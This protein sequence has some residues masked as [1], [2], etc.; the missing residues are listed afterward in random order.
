ML[1]DKS[2]LTEEGA[3]ADAPPQDNP[4]DYDFNV[5]FA[6]DSEDE[7]G[8]GGFDAATGAVGGLDDS[9]LQLSR[10]GVGTPIGGSSSAAGLAMDMDDDSEIGGQRSIATAAKTNLEE[11]EAKK[12]KPARKRRRK[13]RKVVIDNHETELTNDHIRDMLQNTDDI[14]RTMI[15]PASIW[16]DDDDDE[17]KEDY[18]FT[19]GNKN[20]DYKTLVQERIAQEQGLNNNNSKKRKKRSVSFKVN[21]S[22][23]NKATAEDVPC[24][25][26]P[27]LADEVDTGGPTL[28]P[29]LQRLWQDNY[30]KA[31]DRSCPY[32]RLATE[33]QGDDN[34]EE[35]DVVDDVENVRRGTAAD[36]ESTLGGEQSDLDVTKD[37]EDAQ[38]L[39]QGG[40]E[41]GFDFPTNMDDEEDEID[42]PV[43]DF[44]D[45]DNEEQDMNAAANNNANDDDDL[46]ELGM[47]NDMMLDSDE[48]ENNNNNGDDDD[49]DD[50]LNRQALGDVASSST[51]WHKHTVR[52]FQHLKKVMKDP[53]ANTTNQQDEEADA[54]DDDDDD[55]DKKKS[56]T[57]AA[58]TNNNLLL[59]QV[60]FQELTKNVVSRR[61]AASVFFEMLQLKTWDFIDL[62]QDESYGDITISPGIRFS[63]A[64][65]N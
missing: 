44:G 61:N 15:H 63:E 53:N 21:S 14:V 47:V 31:L 55:E 30:W 28:H 49:D 36:D 37:K 45:D 65:P 4:D 24:L 18:T 54:G 57:A 10:D 6:D 40:E 41:D 27:F 19:T 59:E 62:D 17:R 5:P 43:P 2:T 1:G 26:R 8:T 9:A 60:Y 11:M 23:N 32:K 50:E 58:T 42:A 52:V 64:P 22:Y 33:Q 48:D 12:T 25:T 34:D 56:S 51:K 46:L 3:D 39:Q 16:D 35:D 7:Q 29:V 38:S 20:R 13:R